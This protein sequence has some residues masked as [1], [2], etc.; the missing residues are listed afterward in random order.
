MF[1]GIT[2]SVQW[3]LQR[4]ERVFPN[5]LSRFAMTAARFTPQMCARWL[6]AEQATDLLRVKRLA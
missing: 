1:S 3:A 5:K 2:A 4:P 6:E